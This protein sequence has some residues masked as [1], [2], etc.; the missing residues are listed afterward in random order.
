[1]IENG[2]SPLLILLPGD[3]IARSDSTEMYWLNADYKMDCLNLNFNSIRRFDG[4]KDSS[5]NVL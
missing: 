1:M 4:Q 3:P 2:Q 5:G